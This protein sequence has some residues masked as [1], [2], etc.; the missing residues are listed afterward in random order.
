MLRFV[1]KAEY[2]ALLDQGV[3]KL[4]S[5]AKF[6]WHL[7][8]IQDVVTAGHLKDITDADIAEIGGSYTRLL[9]YLATRNRC[10]NIDKFDGSHG[11]SA[12]VPTID[13]VA[14]QKCYLGVD[15]EIIPSASYD[16]M[17]SISVLEHVPLANLDRLFA[18][19]YRITRPGALC[20]HLIDV[21]IGDSGNESIVA[22]I[23]A[24]LQ[25]FEDGRFISTDPS[26]NRSELFPLGFSTAWASNPDNVMHQ[27]NT[28]F[29]ALRKR[30]EQSQ[31]V[32]LVWVGR[33]A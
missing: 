17:F 12:D 8:S 16:V 23:N 33:R 5:K 9:P 25:P 30:R 4:L 20:V 2:W 29:P 3:D 32:S 13:G 18:E 11:G 24:Y 10:T 1:T 27:W 19:Q 28:S 22:A 6:A 15:S 7:K 26:W 31:S 14:V 21:Y